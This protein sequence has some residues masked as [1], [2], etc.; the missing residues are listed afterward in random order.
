MRLVLAIAALASAL[1]AAALATIEQDISRR[2]IGLCL[3]SR[4]GYPFHPRRGACCF[5]DNGLLIRFWECPKASQNVVECD[6][7]GL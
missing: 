6:H 4:R 3:R 1:P 5:L 7:H 2:E